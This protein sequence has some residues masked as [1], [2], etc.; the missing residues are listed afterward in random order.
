LSVR[1]Q[2]KDKTV[3]SGLAM[4][5]LAQ[6]AW[7]QAGYNNL[8][9]ISGG[10]GLNITKISIEYIYERGL[11]ILPD[12]SRVCNCINLKGKLIIT[13]MMKKLVHY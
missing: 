10:V 9:G 8:Y 12:F 4:L 2:F 5:T 3:I 7:V 11:G 13:A 6:G 1:S